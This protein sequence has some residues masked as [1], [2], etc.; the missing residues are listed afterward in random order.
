MFFYHFCG[1]AQALTNYASMILSII[2]NQSIK[3]LYWHYRQKYEQRERQGLGQGLG[4][5]PRLR[6]GLVNLA[7]ALAFPLAEFVHN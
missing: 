6:H 1:L 4:E 3:E 5:R 7:L 2:G